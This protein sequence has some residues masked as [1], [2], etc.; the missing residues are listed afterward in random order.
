MRLGIYVYGLAAIA[1]GIMDIVW[2]GFDPAEEPIQ[3]FGD[4]VPGRGIFAYAVAVLLIAGGAAVLRRRTGRLG[5]A[6]LMIAYTIFAIFWLPRFYTATHVLGLHAGVVI[7]VL[8]G[9][10]QNLIV[11]AA[12]ALIYISAFETGDLQSQRITTAVR[13]VFGLSAMDF[14]LTHLT[15]IPATAALVPKW[16]PPSPDFWA[17]L[18]GIAFVLAGIAIL[19]GIA[20]VLAARLLSLML[21]VF[22]ALA[23]IP[24][25]IAHPHD[26]TAWGINLYNVMAFTSVWIF[27]AWIAQ[28]QPIDAR[29]GST[30]GLAES[31]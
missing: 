9:V 5:C 10:C 3:A 25:A 18:T 4:N 17:V 16:L 19:T 23:L 13:Y 6:A 24:V 28:R 11:V 26:Q 27:G 30:A 29:R 21:V 7:G 8:G 12:A 1:T 22:S 2:R 15:G 31:A 14:G 20:D